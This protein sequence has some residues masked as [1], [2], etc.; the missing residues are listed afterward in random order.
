MAVICKKYNLLYICIPKTGSTSV[1]HMLI[2]Q[3]DGEWLPNHHLFSESGTILV[4][5]KH[6]SINELLTHNLVTKQE[7]KKLHVFT[8]IRNPFDMVLSNYFFEKQIYSRF[9]NGIKWRQMFGRNTY[10]WL[11]KVIG[12]D[13]TNHF[14]WIM[15]QVRRYNF[16]HTHSFEEY[17][18]KFYSGKKKNMY[19]RYTSGAEATYLKLEHIE[20]ELID[21]LGSLGIHENISLP[22]LSK[23]ELKTG[24]YRKY[25]SKKARDIIEVS[26]KSEM[27]TFGY[28]F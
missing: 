15:P 21:F 20:E 17:V 6:G 27:E 8:S 4:N 5:R 11:R 18:I 23:S 14:S 19:N 2:D 13:Q 3:L 9:N 12:F 22:H 10:F 1:S 25:Y 24:N 28:T 16:T 7:L 26:F